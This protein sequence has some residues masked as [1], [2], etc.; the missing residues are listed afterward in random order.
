MQVVVELPR[1]VADPEVVLLVAHNVVEDHEVRE[2]DLVHPA[3]R[4]EAVQVVLG[5]LALDVTGLVREIRARGMDPLTACLQHRSHGMLGEPVDLEVGMQLAQLVRDRRISLRVAQADRRRDVEGTFAARPAAHPAAGRLGRGDEVA[6]QQ[7][8]LH[9]VA[10]MREVT[11]SL[12]R[13]ER[14]GGGLRQRLAP[15][16]RADRVLLAVDHEHRATHPRTEVTHHVLVEEPPGGDGDERLGVGFEPPSHRVLDRLGGVGLG[17]A[18]GH[19]ELD[20]AGVVAP[21]EVGVELRPALV[22]VERDVEGDL[23]I[24]VAGRDRKRRCDEDDA[25]DSLWMLGGDDERALRTERERHEERMLR[26]CRIH[27]GH[28][29]GGELG[30]RVRLGR[31][32]PIRLAVPTRIEDDHAMVP[33]EVRDLHL[34]AARVDDRPRRHEQHRLLA[35]AVDLV[36]GPDAVA[37][38]IAL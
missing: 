15:P 17:D 1:L 10:R 33:R 28:G 21:P 29:V 27:H 32:R 34:P 9:R 19:E 8:D 7:V 25:V 12:D 36:E 6:E 31:L 30:L 23:A 18:L 11:S 14:A 13:H 37:L 38:D 3:D 4:L 35:L 5:G 2:Q 16:W 24:V 20:E 26:S 22:R